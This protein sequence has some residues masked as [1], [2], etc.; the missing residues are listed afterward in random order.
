MAIQINPFVKFGGLELFGVIERARGRASAEE[1]NR[2]MRQYALDTVYRV[3]P[4][5]ELY[6]AARYN[7]VEGELNGIPGT[8]GA[9]RWQLG[10]G[11]F[12]TPAIALRQT[13]YWIDNPLPGDDDTLTRGLPIGSLDMGLKLERE[14]SRGQ[15]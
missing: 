13:N 11:M 3:G 14:K 1:D 4:S 8:I 7:R 15:R 9:N 6:I 12:L 5:D 10:A 2:E